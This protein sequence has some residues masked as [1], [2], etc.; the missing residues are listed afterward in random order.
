MTKS[1]QLGLPT[2]LLL[3][4]KKFPIDAVSTH[5]V[6]E[7]SWYVHQTNF[8]LFKLSLTLCQLSIYQYLSQSIF[9]LI[10]QLLIER[11]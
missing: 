2:L 1:S 4:L 6:A 10:Q 9:Q 5:L 8:Y 7:V 11:K 3:A